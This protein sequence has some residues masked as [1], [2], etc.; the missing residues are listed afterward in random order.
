M[1][2]LF[3]YDAG[4]DA[5]K[6]IRKFRTDFFRKPG[7]T[8]LAEREVDGAVV[9]GLDST[10]LWEV[11]VDAAGHKGP[12]GARSVAGRVGNVAICLNG[13][14]FGQG[15]PWD[16]LVMIASLQASKIREFGARAR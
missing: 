13:S 9:P 16:E 11:D 12:G 3:M 1:I 7:M 14:D 4:A 5:E 6:P 2:F 10:Y 15:M 8:V